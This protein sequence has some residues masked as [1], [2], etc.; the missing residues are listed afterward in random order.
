MGG[1]RR[2]EI[3]RYCYI[4]LSGTL[5][6]PIGGLPLRAGHRIR[7]SRS[8]TSTL[9]LLRIR[10]GRHIIRN[11]THISPGSNRR[12]ILRHCDEYRGALHECELGFILT[13][14]SSILCLHGIWIKPAPP[15]WRAFFSGGSLPGAWCTRH[16]SIRRDKRGAKLTPPST[17]THGLPIR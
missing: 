16:A 7:L 13:S 2:R 10:V 3:F 14:V 12:S 15:L 4:N 17:E 9:D 1:G 5:S 6:L 11:V 8:P